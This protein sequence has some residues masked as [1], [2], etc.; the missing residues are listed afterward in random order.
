MSFLATELTK[1]AETSYYDLWTEYEGIKPDTVRQSALK[2]LID[3][4]ENAT[5][6]S[7]AVFLAAAKN[8]KSFLPAIK[9]LQG[10]GRFSHDAQAEEIV[11]KAI[12]LYLHL[13]PLEGSFRKAVPE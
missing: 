5:V 13:T 1:S 7:N 8:L 4:S 11:A 10:S 12:K 3:T 2:E 9:E 6:V